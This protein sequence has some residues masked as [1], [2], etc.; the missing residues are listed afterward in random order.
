MTAGRIVLDDSSPELSAS[1]K[2]E[3]MAAVMDRGL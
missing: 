1:R 3:L 2:E